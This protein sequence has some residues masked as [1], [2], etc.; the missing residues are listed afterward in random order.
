MI[1]AYFLGEGRTHSDRMDR[2][3]PMACTD[4]TAPGPHGGGAAALVDLVADHLQA[5]EGPLVLAL[6]LA[7]PGLQVI[8]LLLQV[9]QGRRKRQKER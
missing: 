3:W 6:G 1:E 4:T 7:E 9:L 8:H 2:M 5:P